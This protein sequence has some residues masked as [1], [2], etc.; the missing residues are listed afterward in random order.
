MPCP[1]CAG[2]LRVYEDGPDGFYEAPCRLCGARG[3]V[4]AFKRASFLRSVFYDG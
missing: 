4:P 3:T 1:Y 2:R